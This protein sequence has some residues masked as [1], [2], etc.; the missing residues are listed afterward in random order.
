MLVKGNLKQKGVFQ[1][2]E[3]DA[4]SRAY[5]LKEAAKLDLTV[6]QYIERR[7]F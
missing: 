6:D 7:L 1:T 2:D 4:D 5:F 3:I